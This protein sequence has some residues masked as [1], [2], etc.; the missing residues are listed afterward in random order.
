MWEALALTGW[1]LALGAAGAWWRARRRQNAALDLLR[2][3]NRRLS[4]LFES[5]DIAHWTRN[6]ET[7]E[8]WWS[9]VFRR[10]HGIGPEV[11]A[12]RENIL[13]LTDPE[14]QQ[15]FASDIQSMYAAGK[16]EMDYRVIRPDGELRHHLLRVAVTTDPATGHRIAYG[17]NLDITE[18]V[19][20]QQAL[21]E[22]TAYLE[23]IVQ[24]LPMGLSVFDR[25]LKLRV[26]NG[27][28]GAVLG[29]PAELLKE[30]TDFGDLIRVP[31]QRGEYGDVDVDEA[32]AARRALALQ[33]KPHRLE[34]TRP[35]G[36][37]HLVIGEP[38]RQADGDIWGFVTTYT[39]ITEQK[40]EHERLE[41][42]LD[43]LQTMVAN[44]PVGVSMVDRDLRVLV[45]NERLLDLLELPRALFEQPGVTLLDI[46]RYNI[47][48]GEYGPAD[49]ADGMLASMRERALRF[50]PHL[51][52]RTRPNGRSL[53]VQG[54][55]LVTGGFV[56]IYTDITE[57]KAA[58]V[59]I[60]RLARTDPLT[61]LANRSAFHIALDQMLA[62]AARADRPLALLFID[63]DRFKAVNDSLG[64]EAG[65]A[66]LVEAARRLRERLRASD[67][68]A[69]I[70]G[71][72]FVVALPELDDEADAAR[73]ALH[74]VQG[75]G[76]PFDVGPTPEQQQRVYLT[77]SIGIA[78]H[79]RDSRTGSELLRQADLA[80]YHAKNE[81]GAGLRYFTPAMNDAVLRRMDRETRLREAIRDGALVVH[82]QPIHALREGLP[83]LGFEAL[84]RWPQADGSFIPPSD[85]IPLAEESAELIEA[86][87]HW[88]CAEVA[89]QRAQWR[90][91]HPEWPLVLSV[92]LSARQFD[93]EGLAERV[94]AAF[95]AGDPDSTDAA[96]PLLGIELEITEGAMMRDPTRAEAELGRLREL[97]ARVAID[98]F[99]TG[100]SSLA[101]LKHF[102]IDRLKIDRT[103]VRDLD[104][105]ADDAAI[106]TAAVE[107]AHRLGREAVAEGVETPAQ[108][109][110]LRAMG[111]D[112]V[113]GF[114]LSRPMPPLQVPS[115]LHTVAQGEH[116]DRLTRPNQTSGAS[117]AA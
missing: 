77:P 16:G 62:A 30:G 29:M 23:A 67:L 110:T 88:V 33:F 89:R 51:F 71:D 90:R 43:V 31:A 19:R 75:L 44:I 27:E 2:R 11:A 117:D 115:Y 74:L 58:Q 56:T 116:G 35:G 69:R 21:R 32:V 112:A 99:G 101:Y 41:Q 22:R 50:E 70:G 49:D 9:D 105:D 66:V 61:G 72:E 80:M 111:C 6:L 10:L 97:G 91:Q 95:A 55:P 64:H 12:T 42:T 18:R 92:N 48:R 103:F 28:F 52:E 1:L 5:L 38:I 85:F 15:R 26:W 113:Q 39:D 68:V 14:T 65:D 107:L 82:Y 54:Q 13:R 73:I 83:L 17:I 36:R 108:L 84:L 93:R 81:G 94:R 47:E 40:R 106:V 98:D 87:G 57:R 86:L 102:A 60:E 76:E 8:L 4:D 46:L 34:R 53:Q 45:W 100:H 109:E 24:H 7:G 3:E 114:G 25:D 20:L 37:T 96:L 104:R 59:E 78:L 79:P 63:L